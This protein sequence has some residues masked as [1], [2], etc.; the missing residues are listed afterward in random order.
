VRA[1]AVASIVELKSWP[2][3][4]PGDGAEYTVL[5]IDT[6]AGVSGWGESRARTA[7]FEAARGR[8]A[9][10]DAGSAEAVASR[11]AAD[12]PGV[13]AAVNLALLDVLGKVC[14]APAYDVLGGATRRKARALAPLHGTTEAEWL[15]SLRRAREAGFRAVSVP[16]A[17]PEG[18]VRGRGFFRRTR[19][20]LERLRAAAEGVDFVLDCGPRATAAEAAGLARELE[21][22]HLLWL[23]APALSLAE[24]AGIANE[25]AVPIGHGRSTPGGAGFQDLLRADAMDVLRPDLALWGITELR[26]SAALAETY[27]AAMAPHHRGGPLGTAAAIHVAASIPNFVLQEVPLPADER[28]RAMR[29]ELAGAAIETVKDGFL[30]LPAGPGLGVTVDPDALE[31]HRIR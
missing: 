17:L 22:F 26:K 2:L 31:R 8:L 4:Q 29:R 14:K 27:Y 10:Q 12:P 9:G 13:R 30:E 11:L 25:Y 7:D 16:L 28:D 21:G 23:E 5:R 6:D 24:L 18:P 20:S 1:T 19:E 3:R 15:E